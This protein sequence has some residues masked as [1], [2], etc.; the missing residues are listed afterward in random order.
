VSF[1]PSKVKH[2]TYVSVGVVEV[3][4][5]KRQEYTIHIKNHEGLGV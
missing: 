3:G 5:G 1:L 4:E 2:F